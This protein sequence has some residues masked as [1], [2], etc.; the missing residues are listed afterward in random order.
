M[1]RFKSASLVR[2]GLHSCRLLS[3]CRGLCS[4]PDHAL[5]DDLDHQVLVEGK[6]WSRTA[7]LNRPSALNA[8]TTA[9]GARLQKLYKSWEDNPDIG[10]IVMKG[11]GKAFCAGGDVVYLYHMINKGK[12]EECKQFFSTLYAFMYMVGTCLKPHVAI[13]NGI[14]MG[15]GAGVSIPGT[16]RIATDKTVFATPETLIGFH[17]D[18]GASFYLSHLP[19]HL[20]EF[21]ALTGERLN[22]L[23]MIASGLATHYL[24]SSRLPLIEEELG[25]IVTDDPSVIEASLDKYV[26]FVYPDE[27]S[28]LHR[29]ELVDKCFSHD[30]VEEIIDALEWEAGRTN[31]AWCT[32]TLK[33]LKEVS[34]LSLKVALRSIRE[35]RF[36]TLDQCLVREYRMSLQGITKQV[37][38]DFCEGVRARVVEKD[39][40]PKWDPPSVEKVSSDMVDQYFSPLSEFE[41]DLELPTELREAFT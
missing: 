39:F 15:G 5:N 4:L 3:H 31:D 17:P 24:H 38:N 21:V 29:I 22:G 9:M 14:T 27:T 26:E 23:D 32:S 37:S 8:L 41:P 30:T 19:G 1:Q 6:A 28:V 33:R 40:A 36:Q 35:G 13:L 18:A 11:S 10:F 12:I 25:K 16:F 7:I 2:N 20:G 34:P